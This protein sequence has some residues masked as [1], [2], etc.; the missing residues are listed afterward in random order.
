MTLTAPE[1][2]PSPRSALRRATKRAYLMCPPTY[3]DV[4]YAINDWMDPAVR[5]DTELA[6]HQWL[7]LV[8][9]YRSLGHDVS[10]VEPVAGLPDMVFVTDSGLVVDGVAVG[11]RYRSPHRAAEAGHV[12]NWLRANGHPEAAAPEFVNEGEGDFL[13]VGSTILAGTGFRSDPRAHAEV[14]ARLGREVLTLN[15]IDPTYYHLNTALG[16]LDDA[17]IAYLPKAFAP[18]SLTLLRERFPNAVIADE[19]DTAWLGLNLVSDGYH[20]VLAAQATGLA[21]QLR[22]IGFQP[23]PVDFAEFRKSGGGIKCATMEL[24]GSAAGGS[25]GSAGVELR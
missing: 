7:D 3:F 2:S 20:V 14:G 21:D 4:V 22:D 9:T 1:P 15:L 8:R 19:A 12:L 13:V 11:A 25:R 23:V 10:I 16:V 24:R 6:M 17:T 18:D 5:V